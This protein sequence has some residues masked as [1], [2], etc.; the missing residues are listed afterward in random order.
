[1][2]AGLIALV[3]LLAIIIAFPLIRKI[4]SSADRTVHPDIKSLQELTI[5]EFKRIAVA[6][7]FSLHD[8]KLISFALGQG[9]KESRYILLHIVES[10]AAR[11]FGSSTDDLES[12]KDEEQLQG[13]ALQLQARGYAAGAKL[14]YHNRIDEIVR[15]V[16]EEEADLLVMGAHG[17]RGIKDLLYGET[18]NKVR[19]ELKIPVLV[20]NL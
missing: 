13:Y 2:V 20:V 12:R 1:V 6:I 18:I 19:H 8:E 14:G 4:K 5:P 16:Q 10:A 7:D 3:G 11:L 15:I 9:K 17:H